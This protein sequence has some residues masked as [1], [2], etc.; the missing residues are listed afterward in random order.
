MSI[1]LLN[2]LAAAWTLTPTMRF[3]QLV[4]SVENLGWDLL[5]QRVS[6]PRMCWMSDDLFEAALNRWISEPESRK[7]VAT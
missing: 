1:S 4:E 5:P 2:R 3:G 6:S 7:V